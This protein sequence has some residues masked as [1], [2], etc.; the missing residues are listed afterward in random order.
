MKKSIIICV[1]LFG[2]AESHAMKIVETTGYAPQP[3]TE[4]R[5]EARPTVESQQAV[6]PMADNEEE[7]V[8]LEA[9]RGQVVESDVAPKGERKKTMLPPRA[10]RPSPFRPIMEIP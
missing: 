3:Q 8:D 6:Q 10:T 2:V 4:R 7:L 1:A 9:K 5:V